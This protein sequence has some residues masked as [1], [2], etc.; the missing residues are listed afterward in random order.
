LY[1]PVWVARA[2]CAEPDDVGTWVAPFD[3]ATSIPL[4]AR[5]TVQSGDLDLPEAYPVDPAV[6]S[7]VVLPEATSVAGTLRTPASADAITFAPDGG[8]EPVRTYRW[9]VA[10]TAPVP[11]Q[12]HPKLPGSVLGDATFSTSVV[13]HLLE[14]PLDGSLL[15]LLFSEPV[16]A[17]EVR[18]GVGGVPPALVPLTV[19]DP[20]DGVVLDEDLP[21]GGGCL[22]E[23]LG[24]E[25]GDLLTYVASSGIT[26][27]VEVSAGTLQD[28]AFTR[29]RWTAP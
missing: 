28:A 21:A 3:G 15:C 13:P 20:L 24:A 6:V 2:A 8:W 14:A 12:I 5:L 23:A 16:E 19:V 18:V 22:D 10:D 29:H 1:P 25:P 26:D 4:D 17:V 27:Q 9:T 7:V 11:R